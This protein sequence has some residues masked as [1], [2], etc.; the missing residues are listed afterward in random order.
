METTFSVSPAPRR[1]PAVLK[2]RL[3]FGGIISQIGWFFGVI[4]L[5][6]SWAFGVGSVIKSMYFF[7]GSLDVAQGLIIHVESTGASENDV[8]V[9]RMDYVFELDGKQI[10]GR[11]YHTGEFYEEGTVVD[12]EYSF[13]NPEHSR[14]VGMRSTSFGKGIFF[15]LIFPLIGFLIVSFCLHQGRKLISLLKNGQPAVGTIVEKGLSNISVNDVP[16]TRLTFEFTAIDGRIFRISEDT[17][18]PELLEDDAHEKLLYDPKNPEQAKMLDA[19]PGD[20]E[21]DAMGQLQMR[22]HKG[23]LSLVAILILPILS[24]IILFFIFK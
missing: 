13:Q 3:Y 4:G 22:E 11:S 8:D 7:S 18:Q 5:L 24:L 9:M 2:L 23:I 12:V 16:L 19:L 21:F 17:G 1:L 14:I 20:V 15:I 6:F 10:P